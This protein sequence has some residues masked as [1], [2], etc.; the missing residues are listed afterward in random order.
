LGN[1]ILSWVHW[2]S[3]PLAFPFGPLTLGSCVTK[4]LQ[5]PLVLWFTIYFGIHSVCALVG[6]NQHPHV[7]LVRAL[8]VLPQ[9]RALWF[10]L[11]DSLLLSSSKSGGVIGYDSRLRY[12]VYS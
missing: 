2:L 11:F 4:I 7:L 6:V 10:F 5:V 8:V 12:V 9:F 3:N 1:N